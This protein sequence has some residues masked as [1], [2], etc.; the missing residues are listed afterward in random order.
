MESEFGFI[1]KIQKKST[2]VPKK[3][4]TVSNFKKNHNSL[5]NKYLNSKKH[6]ILYL[7]KALFD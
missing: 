5:F 7:T 3:S 2:T 4:T 6:R 1:I